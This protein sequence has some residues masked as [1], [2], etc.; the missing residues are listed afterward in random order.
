MIQDSLIKV[1]NNFMAFHLF[2]KILF[3][4]VRDYKK[5]VGRIKMKI[6][7]SPIKIIK[8]SMS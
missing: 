3:S 4:S 1:F 2:H 6:D 5:S 8:R 7:K